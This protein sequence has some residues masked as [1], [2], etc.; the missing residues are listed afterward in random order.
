[1]AQAL[2]DREAFRDRY[3]RQKDPIAEGRLL[4]R[5]QTVRH[6]VHLLPEQTILELAAG[7]GLFAKQLADVS[8]GENPITAVTY[9]ADHHASTRLPE[10]IAFLQLESVPGALEGRSFDVIVGIDLLDERN[11]AW[12]W[13]RGEAL[14]ACRAAS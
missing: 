11:C 13:T 9:R 5:A 7:D 1:M 8:H 12:L 6:L 14:R 4:W 10:V 2:A 3:R